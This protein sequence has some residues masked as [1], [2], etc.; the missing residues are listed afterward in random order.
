MHRR[1]ACLVVLLAVLCAACR[2]AWAAPA[3][4]QV[5]TEHTVAT[6]VAAETGYR[7]GRTLR[8]GLRLVLQK[9]WHTYWSNPGDAGMPPDATA[10]V[11]GG[12]KAPVRFAFPAPARLPTGPLMGY[13]YEG[14]VLLPFEVAVPAGTSGTL[15]VAVHAEWLVCAAVC[16]PEAADLGLAVSQATAPAP[17]VDAPLFA[18]A[19]AAMPRPSPFA[20]TF[21][22][23][24]T[25]LVEGHG[26]GRDA[27]RDAWFI[28]AAPGL[29]DQ[30]APQ[31]LA[32]SPGR[33]AL[34]LTPAQGWAHLPGGRLAGVLALRDR[35][36]AETDLA[37]DAAPASAAAGES[38]HGAGG[39]LRLVLLAVAG[40][41]VLNLMPCVFPVLAI[42]AMAF[43]R[44]GGGA[45]AATR[46]SA[47]LYTAGV[48]G[49]FAALG[50]LMLGLREA[51]DAVAWGFQ[52]QSPRFVGAVAALLFAVG[53]NLAGVF[54]FGARASG[55]GQSLAGRGGAVGD[56]ATGVLAV[57]V[58]TPCTAPFMGAAVAGALAGPPAAGLAIFL[59]LGAGLALP[60]L[61]LATFP[62]L[63]GLLP[64]PG[65][66]M[67]V[68]RAL[69]AFP[70][71]AAV[72]W[73]VWVLAAL[74][75]PPAVL[76]AGI[77]L[78]LVG[79]AAML[80]GAAQ[81]S[82]SVGGRGRVPALAAAGTL[83]AAAAAIALAVPAAGAPPAA[84][85]RLAADG[86]RPFDA[87][88]LAAA[89]DRKQP[90]FVDMSAA[91]CVTCLVNDQVALAPARVRRAFADRGVTLMRGDWTGRD[92]AI[93]A[94][95]RRFGRDGVPL[96]VY[97]PPGAPP[98]VL[99]Q[100]LT[101]GIVLS[102]IG[103]MPGSAG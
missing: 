25:L 40:G 29:V 91:W 21:R 35:T 96:Y 61:L 1:A 34:S 57:V 82:A 18:R 54:E 28:P 62:A 99:P 9:G 97:F 39:L 10:A 92:A 13:G 93:T 49:A 30:D 27:V 45:R 102:T 73:L 76:G 56:L 78:L 11:G 70:M 19:D 58:A 33:L 100:I 44:H 12:T 63:A 59:A 65:A 66:W 51:G 74:A 90:V 24:G 15:P 68:L 69:L 87:A 31:H 75:G 67:A 64:R 55:I 77:A 26:L 7:P 47:L 36:G 23:D 4:A 89:V 83:A 2:G 86:A 79:A 8:L 32:I 71:F 20:A 88:R 60:T 46:R 85:P 3:P 5:A 72:V 101:P 80:A 6:L 22:R 38:G 37:I 53:L 52:F 16:V 48:L 17:S 14:D 95:L 50:L 98:R 42:K 103:E 41:L 84:A 81:R 43:A 94:F